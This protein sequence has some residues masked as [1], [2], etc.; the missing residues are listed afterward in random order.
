[1]KHCP[2]CAAPFD[3]LVPFCWHCGRDAKDPLQAFAPEP[4]ASDP[5]P[6]TAG[7]TPPVDQVIPRTSDV[8][9]APAQ[10]AIAAKPAGL[11]LPR[12]ALASAGAL[13]GLALILVIGRAGSSTPA[14]A[15][16]SPAPAAA[17]HVPAPLPAAETEPTIESA[18]SPSWVGARRA[19]WGR[20]GSKTIAF[21][22]AARK[23]V[24]V[25]MKSVRP[26]LIVRCLSRTTEVFVATGSAASIEQE[27]DSHAV[28]L[29]F[30]DAAPVVESWSDSVSSQEL[31]APDGVTFARRL[32]QARTVRFGF[33]PYNAPPVVAEFDVR[34][35]DEIIG[36]V[37]GTC[38]WRV[39]PAANVE[40]RRAALN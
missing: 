1:M 26:V 11:R 37:A 24:G 18:P 8:E 20:D 28:R 40:K 10:V 7:T 32:A 12:W 15:Q 3:G 17:R 6:A 9:V 39:D 5:L 2:H 22:L 21:E 36:L 34:G 38:G 30:D 29:Q 23:D 4:A 27:A 13:A 16:T 14:A 35:F 19:T 31:Y 25:W 33:T